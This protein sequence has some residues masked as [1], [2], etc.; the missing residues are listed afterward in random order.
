MPKVARD[1]TGRVDANRTCLCFL[2]SEGQSGKRKQT[3]NG[4][5]LVSGSQESN[6]SVSEVLV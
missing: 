3:Q 2:E 4:K 1:G 5:N 6:R